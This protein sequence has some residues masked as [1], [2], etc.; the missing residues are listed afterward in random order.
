[1]STPLMSFKDKYTVTGSAL[2]ALGASM[3]AAVAS[4]CC[5]G[6]AVLAAIG[7]SGAVAAASLAPYRPYFLIAAFALLGWG[8]WRS[9]WPRPAVDGAVCRT[10]PGRRVRLTLWIS[11]GV[12]LMATV[13]PFFVPMLEAK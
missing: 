12:T 13:L 6:P 9:Y 10:A 1:V 2:G 3:V 8:F 7:A 11:L 4:L 5:V